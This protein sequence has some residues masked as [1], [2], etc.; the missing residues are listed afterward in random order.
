MD[1]QIISQCL[2][3]AKELITTVMT[4]LQRKKSEAL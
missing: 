4:E 2:T 1:V 3:D